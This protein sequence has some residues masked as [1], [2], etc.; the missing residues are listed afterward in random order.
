M[1]KYMIMDE[2]YEQLWLP[3]LSSIKERKNSKIKTVCIL[4]INYHWEE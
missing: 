2:D 1:D 4:I 3:W